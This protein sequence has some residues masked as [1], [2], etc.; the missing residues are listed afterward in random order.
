MHAR[1]LESDVQP[2]YAETPCDPRDAAAEPFGV[3]IITSN[4]V[5]RDYVHPLCD[6]I[7]SRLADHSLEWANMVYDD[8]IP[9]VMAY[10]WERR[11]IQ[12]IHKTEDG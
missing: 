10:K 1:L 9:K 12:D 11:Q 4:D 7:Q 6:E 3:G 5:Q 2:S 8:V